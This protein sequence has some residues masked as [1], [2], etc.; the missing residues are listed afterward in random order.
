MAISLISRDP[1]LH[2]VVPTSQLSQSLELLTRDRRI[3]HRRPG[4][5]RIVEVITDIKEQHRPH[6]RGPH[7]H[8]ARLLLDDTAMAARV[9]AAAGDQAI[10][11]ACFTKIGRIHT[12][13][14]NT[15][16]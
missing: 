10:R 2:T 8:E 13:D 5:V 1:S 3:P 14:P 11:E 15:T 7:A 6:M 12:L 4:Q 16:F 9:A